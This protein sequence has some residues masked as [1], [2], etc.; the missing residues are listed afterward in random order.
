M[1]FI[2]DHVFYKRLLLRRHGEGLGDSE[3]EKLDNECEEL[4]RTLQTVD[5]DRRQRYIDLCEFP[6]DLVNSA[7]ESALASAEPSQCTI[8]Y[9]IP[10]F[11]GRH[12]DTTHTKNINH[13]ASLLADRAI[14]FLITCERNGDLSLSYT[15]TLRQQPQ[16]NVGVGRGSKIHAHERVSMQSR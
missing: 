15:H 12:L 11:N 8:M 13:N 7:T 10:P 9:H 2:H 3:R 4:L 16:S 5:P 1:H 6:S 14:Q